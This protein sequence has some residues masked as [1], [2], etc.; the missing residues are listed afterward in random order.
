MFPLT[1]YSITGQ[2]SQL[3]DTVPCQ[4]HKELCLLGHT[5]QSSS[6]CRAL[7]AGSE[8][9]EAVAYLITKLVASSMLL[10]KHRKVW[11]E[12]RTKKRPCAR[13]F[14]EFGWA[15]CQINTGLTLVT[16]LVN[17]SA[18]WWNGK[19]SCSL[20]KLLGTGEF[21]GHSLSHNWEIFETVFWL[22]RFLFF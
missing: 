5:C 20:V 16:S 8:T 19:A 13:D 4:G 22:C 2:A 1:P 21:S 14:N 3:P 9:M 10:D 18:S 12:V 6:T 15:V 11:D 7:F 17:E